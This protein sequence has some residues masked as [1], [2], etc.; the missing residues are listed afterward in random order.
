MRLPIFLGGSTTKN[1]ATFLLG[2]VVFFIT[3][4][5]QADP[6]HDGVILAPAVAF[7][8]NLTVHGGAFSQYGPLS[9]I[10]SG[11][12]LKLTEPN[13]VSLRY[14]AALQA[15]TISI[16][17]FMV[18]RKLT[19][20]ER[21]RNITLLWI[22]A[23]GVWA[24]RFPGALMAWPSLLSSLLSISALFFSIKGVQEKTSRSSL[25]IFIGG[26][27]IAMSGFAR[28]QSWAMAGAIGI[29]LIFTST[30]S[31]KKVV[32]LCLG[33]ILGFALMLGY[34]DFNRVLKEWWLQSIYWP[35]QIYPA[36]GQDNNYNRF[37]AILYV[38]EG[39]SLL[40][41][42][43][44]ASQIY[45]RY[46]LKYVTVFLVITTS[47][48]V[49]LG[50]LI[51]T[52][53]SLPIRY[54]VLLGEP[55]ERILVSPYYLS[56]SVTILIIYQQIKIPRVNRIPEYLMVSTFGAISVLQLYPQSDVMHLWWIAPLL[57]PSLAI[58]ANSLNSRSKLHPMVLD[59]VLQVFVFFGAILAINFISS[60]WKEYDN[61]ALKK[62]YASSE[63]VD[64]L[65][66]YDQ[67][68]NSA[69]PRKT[70][71][72]C[73]DG[74]YAV[75]TGEYLPVDEWYVNWGFPKTVKPKLGEIRFICGKSYEY[76]ES[77]AFRIGWN[78]I[79]FNQ[80]KSNPEASLAILKKP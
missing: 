23:S 50:F 49:A 11:L 70:S 59:R 53:E 62:T 39:V 63:K 9:P 17:L 54:R 71:F 40:L 57:L 46:S 4:P 8:E 56:V 13:L 31:I 12:W 52:V 6:H 3:A 24:T 32:F 65:T 76:A 48:L 61:F 45:K 73:H 33:Y 14:F 25:Y 72:D 42:V 36:L 58:F 30:K 29:S 68:E 21:S 1:I 15:L 7:S 37:Q 41:F 55:L 47:V 5:L 79:E 67:I 51:P 35:S 2:G 26:L 78:L 60:D 43:F 28:A 20:E 74:I 77:E 34:L 80:S 27:L 22:F 64:G 19:N 44:L 38:I 66:V 75:L 18:L 10:L 16:G 69:I